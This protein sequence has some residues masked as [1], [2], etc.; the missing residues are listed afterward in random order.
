MENS[1]IHTWA[2]ILL[3]M[4]AMIGVSGGA[5]ACYVSIMNSLIKTETQMIAVVDKIGDMKLD[6]QRVDRNVNSINEYLR[7]VKRT[8]K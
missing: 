4:L 2:Q 5:I 3:V 8:D 7:P 6:I 1:R